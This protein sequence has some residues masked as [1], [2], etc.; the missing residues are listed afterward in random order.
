MAKHAVT[1]LIAIILIIYLQRPGYAINPP[2]MI[3][4]YSQN[5]N[6]YVW[7]NSY[8]RYFNLGRFTSEL[9]LNTNSTLIK[10]P[11]KRWQE[12]LDATFS[13]KYKLLDGLAISPYIGQTRNALQSRVVYTSDLKLS[14]PLTRLKYLDIT[15]FV[16]DKSLRRVGEGSERTDSGLGFGLASNSRGLA[17]RSF[18][19][20]AAI[21][22]ESYSLNRIPY[23]KFNASL[24]GLYL[25]DNSDSLKWGLYDNESSKK[26]Y[27]NSDQ[28]DSV[29][30]Q[31]KVE[32]SADYLTKV[33]ITNT[34]T[35]KITA[36]I[37]RSNYYYNPKS[38]KSPIS[39]FDNY[40]ESE[41]YN[42]QL[43]KNLFKRIKLT[44]GYRWYS[45]KQDFRGD[46]LDLWSELGELSFKAAVSIGNA[47]TA[48][49]DCFAGVTSY[50]NLHGRAIERDLRTEIFNS[51]YKHI[52]NRFFWGELKGVFS[53]FHQIY[54]S[55]VYSA[56]NNRNETYLLGSTF[57]WLL[58]NDLN[59]T[60]VFEI[61]ANYIAYDYDR[62]TVNTRNRIF[63]RESMATK[64][65]WR[66]NHRLT[67]T[68]AYMYRYEDYGKLF[69]VENNWQQATGWD[70]R[71]HRIDMKI[72][73]RIFGKLYFEPTYAWELKR[74]FDHSYVGTDSTAAKGKIVRQLKSRDL[75]QTTAL[76]IN[77]GFNDAEFISASYNRRIWKV[78]GRKKDINEFIN[79]S[80][81]YIF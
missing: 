16:G 14:I 73:Y 66:L 56:S 63:R 37:S 62:Q 43:E 50:Y 71:Y 5:N 76:A 68:P 21:S 13:A 11:F 60:Q 28:I 10:K 15:P 2:G 8:Q 74:E 36:N 33:S 47:D 49:F 48:A 12:N 6:T 29:V 42:I 32:R 3:F 55:S 24:G 57:G 7:E 75:R 31:V 53:N 34:L 78:T 67:L 40:T 38:A 70:R 41:T 45:D 61:Q 19:V 9:N 26:Y 46:T 58:A 52:F 72:G 20:E 77:W 17:F 54:I 23:S 69:W 80:V 51:R 59:L 4:N 30:S 81:R 1:P 44:G 25:W 18:P 39:E 79:V 64:I 65:E 27:S 35:T 22:Y